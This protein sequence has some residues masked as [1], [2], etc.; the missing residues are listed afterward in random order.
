[1]LHCM[2]ITYGREADPAKRIRL[3]QGKRIR[4]ARTTRGM[5]IAELAG[6]LGVTSGAVSQWETGRFAP[7]QHHQV[8]I[9]RT[10]DVPHS[11]LF[12]LNG[13]AA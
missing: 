1:M 11:L 12:S 7:R 10:L 9:A 3:A 13:E 8:A 2:V 5:S 6:S 4:N